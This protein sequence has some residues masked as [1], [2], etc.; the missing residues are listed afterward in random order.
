[1]YGEYVK[2]WKE[3]NGNCFKVLLPYW[4]GETGQ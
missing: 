3:M 4:P 2:V 1:V